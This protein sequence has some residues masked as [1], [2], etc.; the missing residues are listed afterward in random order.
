MLASAAMQGIQKLR[1]FVVPPP[2]FPRDRIFLSAHILFFIS[3]S[4]LFLV[5][6]A[7]IVDQDTSRYVP[8]I[9]NVPLSYGSVPVHGSVI[10]Q[11][12]NWV[13]AYLFGLRGI[14]LLHIVFVSYSMAKLTQA[15]AT[16]LCVSKSGM[17]SLF[18]TTVICL[19]S[20]IPFITL[21]ITSEAGSMSSF[22][23][24][25]ALLLG[26]PV[27][28][29]DLLILIA[30]SAYHFSTIPIALTLLCLFVLRSWFKERTF[31]RITVVILG[32][33]LTSTLIDKAIFRVAHPH[34]PR[35]QASFLGAIILN[36]YPLIVESACQRDPSLLVCNPPWREIIEQRRRPYRY[37]PG[38]FLW[39][40]GKIV[41]RGFGD[42]SD[43]NNKIPLA[44]FEEI[45][46]VLTLEAVRIFPF[47]LISYLEISVPRVVALFNQNTIDHFYGPEFPWRKNSFFI[48]RIRNEPSFATWCGCVKVAQLVLLPLLLFACW[49]NLTTSTR[50]SDLVFVLALTYVLN[51]T[52]MGVTG[53]AVSRYHYR[54][55]FCLTALNATLLWI[56]ISGLRGK[57]KKDS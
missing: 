31:P 21:L 57:V 40:G 24:I 2:M 36:Y 34:Q 39:G 1:R 29:A 51:L 3:L 30:C 10:P 35:M 13:P 38:M 5:N 47:N 12:L 15:V 16:I 7:P 23:V 26:S 52:F 25:A 17:F 4:A 32:C 50:L 14:V 55:F 27:T 45:S 6:G 28:I 41:H 46:K 19:F 8:L 44:T 20:F 54:A 9:P 53:T 33:M 11:V 22:A 42:R 43:P 37:Q 56:F 48:K 18:F 49:R